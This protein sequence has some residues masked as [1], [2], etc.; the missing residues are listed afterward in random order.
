MS[1]AIFIHRPKCAICGSDANKI[2]LSK[3]MT[4]PEIWSFLEEYY[5]GRVD[6]VIMDGGDY[7]IAKCQKC[8]FVWQAWVLNEDMMHLL[9]ETW[10]SAEQSLNKKKFGEMALFRKYANEAITISSLIYKSPHQI[11]VLDFGMG[12]GYW[13]NMAKAFGYNVMGL[14]LSQ[15]RVRYARQRG[16][17]VID[18]LNDIK[19][20]KFDFINAEQVFE[21]VVEPLEMLKH[22]SRKLKNNGVI[23]ISVPNGSKTLE[24]LTRPAW[25][26]RK[27]ALHPLEHI[28]CFTHITLK[29]LGKNAGLSFI[30]IPSPIILESRKKRLINLF[31]VLIGSSKSSS[32]KSSS[33]KNR[34][35]A[36]YFRKV[37]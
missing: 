23:R 32:S 12:W 37:Q 26:A 31:A 10:I 28:N 2:I 1:N 34:G 16:I 3:K 7:A 9:Y 14:E 36:L 21:H 24:A 17:E 19:A 33:S 18:S 13:A 20:H 8:E 4:D 30:E 15:K 22:L 27:D 35:T 5:E 25:K 11:D 6:K 29:K